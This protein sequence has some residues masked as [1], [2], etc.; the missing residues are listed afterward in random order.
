MTSTLY[1][2]VAGATRAAQENPGYRRFRD[3]M[4]R[5]DLQPGMILTQ[6]DLC[7]ILGLSLTP[8]RE[9]LVLLQSYGLVD[10]KPRT[11]IHI[12]YPDVA[13]I[14][15]NFQFRIMIEVN[16]LRIFA[17]T[18]LTNW[19]TGMIHSHDES[20]RALSDLGNIDA[21]IAR[22]IDIDRRF[23]ADI[24]GVLGNRAISTTHRRLQ[25]NIGMAR[26]TH[27]RTPFRQQLLDTVEEHRQVLNALAA[28][29]TEGAVD[30]LEAH[31]RASTHR[32]FAA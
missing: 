19:V 24:V 12:V 25:E 9:T 27:K 14:R 23:H 18:D 2:D 16:A 7:R 6:S 20:T 3:A 28:G 21:A 30:A 1:E 11:G 17:Q 32:T 4:D 5:G 22:F 31:F 8:L 26:L 10:V 13:F 15:E 29:D